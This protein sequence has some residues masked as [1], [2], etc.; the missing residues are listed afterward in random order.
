MKY[1]KCY[2]CNNIFKDNGEMVTLEYLNKDIK[3]EYFYCKICL[4]YEKWEN[5][6]YP[7]KTY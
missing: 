5:K 6:E 3:I 1:K 2:K 7:S 4:D